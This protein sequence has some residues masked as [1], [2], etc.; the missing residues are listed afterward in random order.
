MTATR[1][2]LSIR[3]TITTCRAS[4]T[5]ELPAAKL[6]PAWRSL[7]AQ[8]GPFKS[9]VERHEGLFKERQTVELFLAFEK[10]TIVR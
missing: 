4:G 8:F 9:V 3:Q 7:I 10:D 1:H 5:A 2:R 6:E